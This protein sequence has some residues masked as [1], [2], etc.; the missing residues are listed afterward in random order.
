VYDRSPWLIL[1]I[2]PRKLFATILSRGGVGPTKNA[3]QIYV[4][5]A[6]SIFRALLAQDYQ[7]V[8][9]KPRRPVYVIIEKWDARS[10]HADQIIH[11][12][13]VQANDLMAYHHHI[14]LLLDAVDD[15]FYQPFSRVFEQK[16]RWG[17]QYPVLNTFVASP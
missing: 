9:A 4:S 3:L 11:R 14:Y 12:I 5:G 2:N 7:G 1:Y 17:Q 8:V 13:V 15:R 16:P 6:H 10:I